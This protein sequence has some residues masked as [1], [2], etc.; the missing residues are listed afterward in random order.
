MSVS[1]WRLVNDHSNK[2]DEELVVYI[3]DKYRKLGLDMTATEDITPIGDDTKNISDRYI[4]IGVVSENTGLYT[5][6]SGI[7]NT[8]QSGNRFHSHL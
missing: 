2:T 4:S 7:Y 8:P 5:G 1:T 3:K 6:E